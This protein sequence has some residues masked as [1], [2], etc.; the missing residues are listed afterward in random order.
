MMALD[1][2]EGKWHVVYLSILP[3]ELWSKAEFRIPEQWASDCF[4]WNPQKPIETQ[5][6]RESRLSWKGG[7]MLKALESK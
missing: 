7:S 6:Q 1:S 3:A 4:S 2:L 5:K